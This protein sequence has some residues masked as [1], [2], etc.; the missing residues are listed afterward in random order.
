[1]EPRELTMQL[2][3]QRISPLTQSG[4]YMQMPDFQELPQQPFGSCVTCRNVDSTVEF[5]KTYNGLQL[6]LPKMGTLQNNLWI[7]HKVNCVYYLVFGLCKKEYGFA[8]YKFLLMVFK[9]L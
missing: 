4:A 3:G 7:C 5:P 1:M 2:V 6:T 8:Y 9:K